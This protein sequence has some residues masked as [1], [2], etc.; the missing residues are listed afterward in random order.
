MDGILKR[1]ARAWRL[2]EIYPRVRLCLF[3][4]RDL[5][6]N[7]QHA[8]SIF[9]LKRRPWWC[10]LWMYSLCLTSAFPVSS[11]FHFG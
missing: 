6:A 4:D 5:A 2:A 11:W 3:C 7:W 8:G 10:P 9:S 1:F